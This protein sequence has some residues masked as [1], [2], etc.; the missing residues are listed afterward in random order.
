MLKVIRSYL[1]LLLW[2]A[3]A[4]YSLVMAQNADAGI[5]ADAQPGVIFRP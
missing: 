3:V 1:P 5:P 2:I 4:T